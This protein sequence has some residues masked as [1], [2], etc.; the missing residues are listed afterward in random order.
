VLP[1]KGRVVVFSYG[2]KT[3][4][5]GRDWGAKVDQPGI[6]LLPNLSYT[7]VQLIADQVRRIKQPGDIVVASI[8]WGGNWDYT[9]NRD[10]RAF[11]HA[12]IDSADVDVLHGHSSQMTWG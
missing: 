2:S 9:I 11:A 4:G 3:S 10:Q 12:L 7:T 1:D 5:I 8:H 6:N